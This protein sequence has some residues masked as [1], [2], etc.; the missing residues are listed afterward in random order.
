[1]MKMSLE[2]FLP[3]KSVVF[4]TLHRCASQFF[5]RQL[6][7]RIHRC[8]HVDYQWLHYE[9]RLQGPV[10]VRRRNHVYGPVRI[11]EREHPAF[12][13]TEDILAACSSMGLK[14]VFVIRDP[15]DI[16]VSMYYSFGFSHPLSPQPAIREYQCRRRAWIRSQDLDSY[17][18]QAAPALCERFARIDAL[19]RQAKDRL[20]LRYEDMIDD[21]SGFY[22]RL[23]DF[24]EI[25]DGFREE[26]RSLTRPEL[27]EDVLRHKRHGRPGG[28]QAKLGSESIDELNR[29]FSLVLHEYHYGK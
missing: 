6:L 23:N 8:T 12:G 5:S 17:V 22:S 26:A 20:L 16:L 28:F 19:Y 10:V 13:I 1:M 4:T 29:I 14:V 3:R 2:G 15:R 24:V 7:P 21:F 25:D 18:V 11:L 27:A 9:N